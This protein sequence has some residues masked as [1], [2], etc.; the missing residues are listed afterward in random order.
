MSFALPPLPAQP[1]ANQGDQI[2]R[3]IPLVTIM[4]GVSL[5]APAYAKGAESK[6]AK[7]W[8]NDAHMQKMEAMIGKMD[9]GA[10]KKDA[11]MALSMS[12]T[13][14]QSKDMAGCVSHMKDAHAAM[15]I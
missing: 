9:A 13:A 2:M 12:R 10:K 11:E 4:L 8:C 14:M 1:V 15:G 6:E 3:L 5:A 7:Q